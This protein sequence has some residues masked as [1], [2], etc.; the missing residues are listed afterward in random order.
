MSQLDNPDPD[1]FD[2]QFEP[3]VKPTSQERYKRQ[4]WWQVTFPVLLTAILGIVL[5]VLLIVFGGREAIAVVAHY[6]TILFALL[7]ALPILLILAA[8]PIALVWLMSK[9]LSKTPPF[10][11]KAQLFTQG[12]YRWVDDATDKVAGAVIEVKSR[13]AGVEQG[14]REAGIDLEGAEAPDDTTQSI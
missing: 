7:V 8:I 4:A 13:M 10:T 5:L 14:L 12:V 11:H 6:S 1:V 9:A 3:R 2:E